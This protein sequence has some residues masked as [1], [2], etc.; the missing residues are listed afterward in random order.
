MVLEQSLGARQVLLHLGE[1]VAE[2]HLVAICVGVY[3]LQ[4][5]LFIDTLLP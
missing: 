3:H 5:T 2:G 4:F 1:S